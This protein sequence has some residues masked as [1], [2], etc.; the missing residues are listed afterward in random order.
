MEVYAVQI[1][2]VKGISAP[3]KQVLLN[4]TAP[5]KKARLLRFYRE[6]DLLRGLVGDLLIRHAVSE[7]TGLKNHEIAFVENEYGKPQL[8]NRRRPE[9]D[10]VQ[11]NLS[12]SGIW[13]VAVI[14]DQHRPV[15][16]DV[17]QVQSIDL[18]ISE[19][20]FSPDEHRDLMSKADKFDYFFTLWALKESYIKILGKG[21][22]HPLNAFS[23]AFDETGQII[24]KVNGSRIG[25]TF[26]RMYPIHPEYKM[27]VCASHPDI[28]DTVTQITVDQLAEQF[29]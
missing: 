24:I 17:E 14:D 1:D 5:E 3:V 4:R 25:D 15:G 22:S 18:S 7:K 20:Y 6:E 13:V 11:F 16:I 9:F 26:F 27:A 28:P 10:S 23:M 29:L 19:N 2:F 8:K 12:H 21:L